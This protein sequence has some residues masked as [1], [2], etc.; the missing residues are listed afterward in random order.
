[1]RIQAT[2]DWDL[3]TCINEIRKIIY[4]RLSEAELTDGLNRK[5]PTKPVRS[6]MTAMVDTPDRFEECRLHRCQSGRDWER[7]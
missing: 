4:G 1:M 3:V 7:G 2:V 5:D 6:H